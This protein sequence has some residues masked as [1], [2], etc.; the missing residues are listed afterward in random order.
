MTIGNETQRF[1]VMRCSNGR[2]RVRDML[3]GRDLRYSYSNP[4]L[5]A[6]AT[7]MATEWNNYYAARGFCQRMAA[8]NDPLP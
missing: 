6:T 5:Y 2:F 8:R 4:P 3:N 7:Q 1:V